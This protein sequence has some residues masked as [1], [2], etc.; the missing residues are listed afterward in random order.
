MSDPNYYASMMV[1]MGDADG[2]VT[3]SSQDYADA[4]RP[5]LQVIGLHKEGVPAGVNFVLT[6]NRMFLLTDTTVNINPSAEQLAQI[7]LQAAKVAEYFG[8]V[9]KIA[10]LSYSNFTGQSGTPKNEKGCGTCQSAAPR[11]DL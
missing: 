7:A 4:V 1:L 2:M 6:E 5:I 8:L 10:M 11:A 3:G 9:P